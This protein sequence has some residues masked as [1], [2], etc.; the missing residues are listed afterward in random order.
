MR[1]ASEIKARYMRERRRI[2]SI[3]YRAEKK[4]N[5]IVDRTILPAIPKK[6][7]E[8]SVR[9][10]KGITARDVQEKAVTWYDPD[11]GEILGTGRQAINKERAE[12]RKKQKIDI[13]FLYREW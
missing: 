13:D 11:T 3:I 1:K 6:I 4:E 12:N 8:A 9:R 5:R 2:Q 10:L 7:T